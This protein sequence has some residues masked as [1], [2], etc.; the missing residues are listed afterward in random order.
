MNNPV[1]ASPGIRSDTMKAIVSRRYGGPDVLVLEA[2]A[3]PTR[4]TFDGGAATYL[5]TAR[6]DPRNHRGASRLP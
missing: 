1:L 4:F 5:G 6:S 3:K 2:V